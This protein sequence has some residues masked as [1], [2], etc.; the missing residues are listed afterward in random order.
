MHAAY[1]LTNAKEVWKTVLNNST[2]I[3]ANAHK[4]KSEFQPGKKLSKVWRK[5]TKEGSPLSKPGSKLTKLRAFLSKERAKLS[6]EGS[7][8]T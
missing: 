6:K 5:L 8:L 7:L 2:G 3:T 4:V 1:T